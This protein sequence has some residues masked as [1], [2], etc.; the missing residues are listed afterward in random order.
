MQSTKN[1]LVAAMDILLGTFWLKVGDLHPTFCLFVYLTKSM[2]H[3]VIRKE[4]ETTAVI[5]TV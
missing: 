4:I 1:G 3:L 2:H 5:Q